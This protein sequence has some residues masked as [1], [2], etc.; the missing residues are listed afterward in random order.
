VSERTAE[1]RIN[2]QLRV[3]RA[4]LAGAIRD[5]CKAVKR[6]RKA[7]D[8]YIYA[9]AEAEESEYQES[10]VDL[11]NKAYKKHEDA[12]ANLIISERAALDVLAELQQPSSTTAAAGEQG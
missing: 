3:D 8:V 2:A 6:A 9:Q 5:L 4:K 10:A 12:Q 7:E 1:E 11:F